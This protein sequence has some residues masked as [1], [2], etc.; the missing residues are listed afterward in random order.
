MSI[1]Q[2]APAGPPQHPKLNHIWIYSWTQACLLLLKQNINPE[3]PRRT[4]VFPEASGS[5]SLDEIPTGRV[6]DQLFHDNPPVPSP[7]LMV[8]G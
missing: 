7:H 8:P 3:T 4:P 5:W 6:G 2:S 1:C